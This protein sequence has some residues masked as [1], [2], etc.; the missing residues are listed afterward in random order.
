MIVK[1]EDCAQEER[2]PL[3]AF[4]ARN[5]LFDHQICNTD[6]QYLYKSIDAMLK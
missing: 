4:S 2:R 1:S 5:L 6:F 3:L